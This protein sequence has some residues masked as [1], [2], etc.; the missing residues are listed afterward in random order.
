MNICVYGASSDD[1]SDV[2]KSQTEL[3]GRCI[4]KNGDTLVYGGGTHGLMGAVMRGVKAENGKSIG[5]APRFFD[6][7]DILCKECSQFIFT[8]T[9]R[10]RK[11]LMEE[12]SDAFIMTPGGIGTYEEFFEILT[13][14]QLKKHSKP[15]GILNINGYFDQLIKLLDVTAQKGFMREDIS[16][17]YIVCEQPEELIK[18][19]KNM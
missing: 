14:K 16:S 9:M 7:D 18:Q 17:D 1:I 19:L 5:I 4:A 12:N 2:Y 3:L 8:D 6:V 11:Q 13:L 10:Q 15:I